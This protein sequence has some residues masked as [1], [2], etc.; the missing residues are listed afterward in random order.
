MINRLKF[1]P[2]IKINK[3]SVTY[4]VFGNICSPPFIKNFAIFRT[5]FENYFT[6]YLKYDGD[7]L[8]SYANWIFFIME[9]WS[10]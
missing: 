5:I 7:H 1:Y 6:A 10:A 3:T 9:R 8:N 4:F 2:Q